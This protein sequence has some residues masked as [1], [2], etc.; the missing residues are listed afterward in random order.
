MASATSPKEYRVLWNPKYWDYKAYLEKVV[1]GEYIDSSYTKAWEVP[2]SI[3]DVIEIPYK[4]LP[5]TRAF[6]STPQ[7]GKLSP[8]KGD[9]IKFVVCGEKGGW[10]VVAT[11]IV[12]SDGWITDDRPESPH[13][14]YPLYTS[15]CKESKDVCKSDQYVWI[16]VVPLQQSIAFTRNGQLTW[17]ELK[18][19][20]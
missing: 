18:S 16:E 7:K 13:R 2:E 3:S 14:N 12:K 9:Q 10:K 4:Y 6:K 11:G 1:S 17:T 15:E 20:K 19:D 8:K 5:Q